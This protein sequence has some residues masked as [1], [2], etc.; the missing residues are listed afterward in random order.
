[1]L[2]RTLSKKTE[3]SFDILSALHAEATPG[4][5]EGSQ[6]VFITLGYYLAAKWRQ[7]RDFVQRVLQTYER[8]GHGGHRDIGGSRGSAY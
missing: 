5:M 4:L 6:I 1:M 7:T 2:I 8:R 3:K